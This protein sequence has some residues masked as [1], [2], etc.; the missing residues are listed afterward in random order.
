[1]TDTDDSLHNDRYNNKQNWIV[2][3]SLQMCR[4]PLQRTRH[5]MQNKR[6]IVYRNLK[7]PQSTIREQNLEQ[8][9]SV[10]YLLSMLISHYEMSKEGEHSIKH[11]D[12]H[13]KPLSWKLESWWLLISTRVHHQVSHITDP[14]TFDLVEV[15]FSL[16]AIKHTTTIQQSR[17][18]KV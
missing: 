5:H 16:I 14:E 2:Q 17:D 4:V 15:S 1:M 9:C 7:K 13:K 8:D 10:Q 18:S 11:E 3:Q 12:K 6:N